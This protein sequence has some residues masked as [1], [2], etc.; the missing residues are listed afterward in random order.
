MKVNY[1]IRA[2]QLDL[3]RQMETLD[4]I[5]EFIDFA[6]AN[7]YNALLLYLE[8][9]VRTKCLDLG[10]KQGYSAEELREIIRYAGNRGLSVIPGLAT[11]G[12]SDLLLQKEEYKSLSELRGG[13]RG[14]FSENAGSEIDLCISS[15]AVRTLLAEYLQEVSEIFDTSCYLHIGADEVHNIGYCEECRK[16]VTDFAAEQQLYLDHIRF[17][18]SIAA[19][20]GKQVM[21]WDDMFEYYPDILPRMPKDIIMVSWMYR[22]NVPCRYGMFYNQR[23]ENW[24]E[25]YDRLGFRYLLAPA[26]YTSGNVRT[27][28][29]HAEN[30]HPLGGLMTTWEKSG[31]LMYKSY[32]I[33]ALAGRLWGRDAESGEEVMKQALVSLFGIQ[34]ELF[35]DAMEAYAAQ[36]G[37]FPAL[38]L[39]SL[40]SFDFNG[41][42]HAAYYSLQTTEL[43]FRQYLEKTGCP[44]GKLVLQDIL[45]DCR[46]K[47]L[48]MRSCTAAWKYLKKLRHESFQ[49]LK[50]ELETFREQYLP[51]YEQHR[52]EN[53]GLAPERMLQNWIRAL[54]ELPSAVSNGKITVVFV[55]PDYYVAQWMRIFVNGKMLVCRCFKHGASPCYEVHLPLPAEMGQSDIREIRFESLGFG[56]Q[57]IAYVSAENGRGRFVPAG[58]ISA[59]GVVEHPEG[60]LKNDINYA[61]LGLRDVEASYRDRNLSSLVSSLTLT[62]KSEA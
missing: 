19:G 54:E 35:L 49:N 36:Q 43:I 38:S 13:I 18:H 10:E 16:K 12:H 48:K 61:F 46:L 57:G 1:E 11:L 14:R 3:A 56:G 15:E 40:L 50:Q 33:I 5:K 34:D 58:V 28:T 51:F 2:V 29:E 59:S 32:P 42:N 4:F 31:S 17:V 45:F 24:L 27:F 53:A 37:Y 55:Q 7:H 52:P 8:W 39:E 25:R 44:V 62:M 21:M 30:H 41:P 6:A 20:L 60:I 47:L 26:D 9:R 23:F 22:E